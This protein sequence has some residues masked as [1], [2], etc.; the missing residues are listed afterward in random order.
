MARVMSSALT[1][2]LIFWAVLIMPLVW[3]G[4]SVS[5][6]DAAMEVA[7]EWVHWFVGVGGVLA[8]LVSVWVWWPRRTSSIRVQVS[9]WTLL[10]A[11]PTSAIMIA[12]IVAAFMAEIVMFRVPGVLVVG[13]VPSALV[14]VV[15]SLVIYQTVKVVSQMPL[16]SISITLTM[17]VCMTITSLMLT[18]GASVINAINNWPLFYNWIVV[19]AILVV[20]GTALWM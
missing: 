20:I 9:T 8:G 18:A 14:A 15:G 3:V 16:L 2:G 7:P 13:L 12:G 1:L 11:F 19:L 10:V 17:M 4:V 5:A 6:A